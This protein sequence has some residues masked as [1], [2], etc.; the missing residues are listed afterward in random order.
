MMRPC[1]AH[2]ALRCTPPMSQPTTALMPRAKLPRDTLQP[3]AD[4]T[5]SGQFTHTQSMEIIPVI[6]LKDGTVVRARM[7]RRDQYQPIVTPLSPTSDPLDVARA[8]L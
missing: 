1:S 8:L 6:D 7:G 5:W 4:Y 3:S 2:A